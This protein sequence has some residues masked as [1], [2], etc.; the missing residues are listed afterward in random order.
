M[1]DDVNQAFF[2]LSLLRAH[3]RALVSDW[4]LHS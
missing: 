3:L 4:L 1:M 2:F